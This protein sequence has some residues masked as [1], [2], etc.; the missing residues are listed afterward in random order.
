MY[1]NGLNPVHSIRREH[2]WVLIIGTVDTRKAVVTAGENVSSSIKG[3]H[4]QHDALE[5][6]QRKE[7]DALQLWKGVLIN[8]SLQICNQNGTTKWAIISPTAGSHS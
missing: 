6:R 7:L 3:C 8:T 4:L 2:Q 1:R 5:E